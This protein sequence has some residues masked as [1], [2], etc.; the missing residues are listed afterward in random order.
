MRHTRIVFSRALYVRLD[1]S[2]AR[3]AADD[4]APQTVA[5]DANLIAIAEPSRGCQGDAVAGQRRRGRRLLRRLDEKLSAVMAQ[6]G[7]RAVV[8]ETGQREMARAISQI[9]ANKM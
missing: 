9:F 8:G 5:A 2:K 4:F 6:I 3:A 1:E 7:Y